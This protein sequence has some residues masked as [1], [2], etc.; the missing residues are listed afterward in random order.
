MAHMN[1][2]LVDGMPPWKT[3][4]AMAI[5]Q[6]NSADFISMNATCEQII[7]EH[8]GLKWQTYFSSTGPAWSS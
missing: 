3:L 1:T 4:L 6:A 5:S 8:P 7:A 2:Q